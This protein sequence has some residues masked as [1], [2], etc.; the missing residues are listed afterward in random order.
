MQW[1]K[2]LLILVLVEMFWFASF[3]L[4]EYTHSYLFYLQSGE[5]GM[6]HFFDQVSFSYGTIAAVIPPPGLIIKDTTLHELFAYAVQTIATALFVFI[7]WISFYSSSDK[8][9]KIT[10]VKDT[11]NRFRYRFFISFH[12]CSILK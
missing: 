6:I 3:V 4:H 10:D 8:N 1:K 12:S 5:F 2:A 7:L 9:K 11:L